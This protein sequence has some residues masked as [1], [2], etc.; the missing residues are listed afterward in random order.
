MYD[1]P[2]QNR[3]QLNTAL[4]L[5]ATRPFMTIYQLVCGWTGHTYVWTFEPNRL[6]QRCINCLHETP[7]WVVGPAT[8]YEQARRA[9]AG[10]AI[11]APRYSD[12]T[13]FVIDARSSPLKLRYSL[14]PRA[15]EGID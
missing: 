11:Q 4:F 12:K 13:H 6:G 9:A 15:T 1:N 7:G 14:N 2:Q 5:K 8:V 3:L 10:L